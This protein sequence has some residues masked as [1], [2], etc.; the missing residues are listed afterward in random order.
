MAGIGW[1]VYG[2]PNSSSYATGASPLIHCGGKLVMCSRSDR[3]TFMATVL[4]VP[5]ESSHNVLMH[6]SAILTTPVKLPDGPY[7]GNQ[8]GF[9]PISGRLVYSIFRED[10]EDEPE[11]EVHVYDYLLPLQYL[12]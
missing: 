12:R 3:S 2:R 11:T 6:T 5:Y 8:F 10:G 1:S 9:C 4:D 7:T